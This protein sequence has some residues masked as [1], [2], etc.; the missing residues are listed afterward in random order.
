MEWWLLLTG[1]AARAALEPATVEHSRRQ[2]LN[3]RAASERHNRLNPPHLGG[4]IRESMDDVG[5]SV[6]ETAARLGRRRGTLSFL[7]NGERG[8][9]RTWRSRWGISDGHGPAMDAGELRACASAPGSGYSGER[10][11]RVMES[12]ASAVGWSTVPP[13]VVRPLRAGERH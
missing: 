12:R 1:F 7:L 5:W 11:A 4:L 2:S 10:T 9:R 3:R 8:C 13:A 6:T